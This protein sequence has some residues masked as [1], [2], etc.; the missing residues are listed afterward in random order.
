MDLTEPER[1][2]GDAIEAGNA[3]SLL[4][5]RAGADPNVSNGSTWGP[6]RTIRSDVLAAMI[7]SPRLA[8]RGTTRAA[9]LR[10]ARIVGILDLESLEIQ[11][12]L[13]FTECFFDG[14][15][16]MDE[17]SAQKVKLTKCQLKYL[18]GRQLETR[19][20]LDLA[21]SCATTV[22]LEDA[23][24]RG[25]LI[26]NATRLTN[27]KG[28]A[29]DADHSQID[30]GMYARD[31]FRVEGEL[32]LIGARIGGQLALDGAELIN[33]GADALSADGAR[34]DGD[35]FCLK[36]FC[37]EGELR[38]LGA[39]IS[40]Q[41]G[42]DGAQL[43]NPGGIVLDVQHAE[44]GGAMYCRGPFRAEGG[45]RLLGVRVAGQ[46]ELNGAQL[47]NPNGNALWADHAQI[48]E[49]MDCEG[50]HV[51]GTLRLIG[52]RIGGQ[53][54]L[55]GA[56]C[57]NSGG[58]VLTADGVHIGADLICRDSFRAEGEVR[59]LGACIGGQLDFTGVTQ[60]I[61]S[62]GDALNAEQAQIGH[63]ML[64]GEH[65]FAAGLLC[66]AGIQIGGM[67]DLHGAC[68]ESP[69]RVALDLR[70]ANVAYATLP[71]VFE[72]EGL[73]DLTNAHLAHLND[74]W[75]TTSYVARLDGLIYEAINPLDRGALARLVWLANTDGG[76]L[77]QPYEQLAAV[78]RRAGRDND[79][80]R[81]AIAKE[82]ERRSELGLAGRVASRFLDAT[83]AFGY[84]PGR[85]MLLLCLLALIGWPVF[86]S[87]NAHHDFVAIH[88]S[89]Q[90]V[91]HF[92]AW[93]YSLDCVLPVVDLG[94]RNYWAPTGLVLYWKTISIIAGWV[95]VTVIIGT[96][97]TRLIRD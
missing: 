70:R 81:V 28:V 2:L 61:N 29:L 17:A 78:L 68:L 50:L 94:E 31:T 30:G 47:S 96:V 57:T 54:N 40:G 95:L 49:G 14:P 64:C 7:T 51:T 6:E 59:I 84:K 36:G 90:A 35:M 37:A 34:I 11:C 73:I 10:F 91:P 33:P 69:G 5:D 46:L 63:N 66:L 74:D 75:P 22:N 62:A 38:L 41:L 53:L 97:T 89:T 58:E 24:I 4:P 65:F 19:G 8:R 55:S 12:P 16:L 52:A 15:I 18:S 23:H 20:D 21:G 80:R 77:P 3:L 1:R 39:H 32:R 27:P 25:Q 67:L 76:F 26:L 42:L 44:I 85:G 9:R 13:D 56:Q 48:A 83:V 87:A 82:R 88:Q 72:P 71:T 45:L 92:H 60:L 79:A 86:A 93:L 43:T